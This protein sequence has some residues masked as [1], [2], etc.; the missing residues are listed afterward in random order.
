MSIREL[1]I[2]PP[3]AIA[4][5]GDADSPMDNY[6]VEVDPKD[7]LGYR[8]L[9]PA[10]TFDVD[11][12]TGEIE[13]S[14]TPPSPLEFK[15]GG[16][17]RPVAPFF[18]AWALTEEG[19]EQLSLDLLTRHGLALED[20]TWSVHVAN[21]KV[22]R[23][24]GDRNDRV[25]ARIGPIR[26]HHRR[27]LEG[28]C[29]NFLP[30]KS[31]PF[32]WVQYMKPSP[33]FPEIRLRFTPARGYVYGSRLK[34]SRKDDAPDENLRDVV[35]DGR[36]GRWPGY[37][38]PGD[39]TSTTP[40][41]IFANRT[42]A[43]DNAVSLGYL[44]DECDGIVEVR[45]G[46]ELSAIARVGAGPPTYAPDSFPVRS[47][48]DEL[49]QAMFGLEL[50]RG[51]DH[52]AATEEI[53]RR[54]LETVRLMNT[55]IMNGNPVNGQPNW[56]NTMATQDTDTGRHF[57]PIMSTA[58]VDNHALI[59][60]HQSVLTALRAG[61]AAWFADVLREFD[62]VGDLSHKGRR[63]MPALM[64]GADGRYLALT[65]RQLELIRKVARGPIAPGPSAPGGSKE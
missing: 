48:L 10:R 16:K 12:A 9:K 17:V 13:R 42:D 65:R 5:L 59:T 38:D 7:P 29:S 56:V 21:H 4:R 19:L 52:Y 41:A 44:D 23:R 35:Y 40:F 64:R 34:T 63:K 57:E 22:F 39:E 27:A 2:L 8:Q 33:E 60:L 28:R 62:E 31:I 45:L 50:R 47:V 11:E 53:V 1:R 6:T 18:E 36:K 37:V 15:L 30:G 55:T 32:G 51:D 61:T 49:E 3:L 43:N 14:R 54:A 46:K 24:T 20:I 58:I 25:E 26:D